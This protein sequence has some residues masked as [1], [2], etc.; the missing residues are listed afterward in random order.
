MRVKLSLMGDMC[1]P[2]PA[3]L[4]VHEAWPILELPVPIMWG[5]GFA[6]QQNKLTKTVFH[7]G[8]F[9]ALEGHD[10]GHLIPHSWIPP[11]PPMP[12]LLKLP[13]IIAFSKRKVMFSSSTVKAEDNQIACTQFMGGML[14]PMQ[15]CGSP[16]S[17]PS[18]YPVFNFLHSVSVNMTAADLFAGV[19]AMLLTMACERLG[20]LEVF[21]G[22][23]G[24]EKELVGA[25]NFWH[26]GLKVI[27]G[28][29]TNAS[30]LGLTRE[31]EFKLE[32]F[33]NY[34]GIEGGYEYKRDGRK[35][36]TVQA[37]GP[38]D[39]GSRQYKHTHTYKDDNLTK[40][41]DGTTV[42]NSTSVVSTT[43]SRTYGDGDRG[44]STTKSVQSKGDV[45]SVLGFGSG[46][47][48]VTTTV[49]GWGPA[50]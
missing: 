40:D 29:A 48:G 24:W 36:L 46:P 26:L 4:G 49:T 32:L 23:D 33:S 19:I 42:A 44:E 50:L 11:F 34:A 45:G 6:L 13:M 30:K 3:L 27:V 18:S 39:G 21:K 10:C 35:R 5:P 8:Q 7:K 38:A 15:T 31:G 12:T 1:M 47:Q 9:M 43:S 2:Q 20:K 16:M 41:E 17:I 14:L 25:G 22:L 28:L 37:Q